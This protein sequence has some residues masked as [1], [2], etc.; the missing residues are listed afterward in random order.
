MTKQEL[1]EYRAD[2]RK[3]KCLH[4]H[5]AMVAIHGNCEPFNQS[6]YNKVITKQKA[7]FTKGKGFA[8][9]GL[10]NHNS[11]NLKTI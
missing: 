7:S 3:Q 1:I 10:W 4:H 5:R 6:E 11:I 9:K 2:K 8:S